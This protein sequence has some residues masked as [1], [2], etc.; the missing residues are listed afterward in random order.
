MRSPEDH[1]S[2]EY[3][4][5]VRLYDAGLIHST[6]EPIWLDGTAIYLRC[7]I[8]EAGREVLDEVNE[9]MGDLAP[10]DEPM[11]LGLKEGRDII[12]RHVNNLHGASNQL[13][14]RITIEEVNQATA[15]VKESGPKVIRRLLTEW[16]PQSMTSS[17][18]KSLIDILKAS[19]G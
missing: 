12:I 4:A 19:F 15:Q 9:R 10:G 11:L 17:A 14:I 6:A 2:A 5:F 8:T 16:V 1:E 13:G 7:T 18:I 3:A